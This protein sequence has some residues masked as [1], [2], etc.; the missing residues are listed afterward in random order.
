MFHNLNDYEVQL[1]RKT[2]SRE[3]FLA[4]RQNLNT[5]SFQNAEKSLRSLDLSFSK[6][7]HSSRSFRAL[8]AK[9]LTFAKDRLRKKS[10]T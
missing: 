1:Q 6:V 7:W 5:N 9:Y 10:L 8:L 2:A 4:S 3:D